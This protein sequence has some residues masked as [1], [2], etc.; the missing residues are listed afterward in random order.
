MRKKMQLLKEM[1]M[2]KH[3]VKRMKVEVGKRVV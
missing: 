3:L 2:V 1:I